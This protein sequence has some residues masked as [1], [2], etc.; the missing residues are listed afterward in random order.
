MKCIQREVAC[1]SGRRGKSCY[2]VLCCVVKTAIQYL[3][4]EISMQEL[5]SEA[6]DLCG[7][8][9]EAVLKALS[10][11]T[12]DIWEYGNRQELNRVMGHDLYEKPSPKDLVI[13]LAQ[14]LWFEMSAGY[15]T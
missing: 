15:T 6:G 3:P 11:A 13:A 12:K 7:K 10:R 2:Y 4:A 1:I 5:C 8:K 14:L 9:K